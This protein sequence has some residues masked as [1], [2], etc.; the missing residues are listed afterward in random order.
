M[1][2]DFASLQFVQQFAVRKDLP[3]AVNVG[4]HK[5]VAGDQS[6]RAQACW[7]LRPKRNS[8]IKVVD[9]PVLINQPWKLRCVDIFVVGRDSVKV[10]PRQI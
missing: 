2:F 1:P 7:D 10:L 3:L 6:K 5:I 8:K 9:I 4:V